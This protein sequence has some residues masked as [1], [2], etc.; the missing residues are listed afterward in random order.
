MSESESPSSVWRTLW[1][2]TK[3]YWHWPVL[4]VVGVYVYHQYMPRIDLS[5]VEGQ[6]PAFA[7]ETID[8]DSFRL[9]EHRGEVG[10]VN[11]WATWCLPCRAVW[12]CPASWTCS[13]N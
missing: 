3:R 6:A 9:R 10:V 7:V 12:R 4:V 5:T 2:Y 13:A 11:V 1:T 8:G